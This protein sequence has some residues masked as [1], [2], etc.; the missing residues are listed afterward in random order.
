MMVFGWVC[1]GLGWDV[2]LW[3]YC[4]DCLVVVL[5]LGVGGVVGGGSCCD[6]YVC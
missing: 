5:L 6:W 2:L 1:L 4:V 3:V